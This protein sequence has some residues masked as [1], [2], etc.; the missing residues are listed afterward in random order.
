MLHNVIKK[1]LVKKGLKEGLGIKSNETLH[2]PVFKVRIVNLTVTLIDVR[3]VS[4][5]Q[6]SSPAKGL[7][8]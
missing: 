8:P 3:A 7:S 5:E 2:T 4:S 1:T 6:R